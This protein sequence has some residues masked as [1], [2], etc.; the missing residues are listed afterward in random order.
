MMNI[1]KKDYIIGLDIGSSSIKLAEF[2]KKEDGLHLVKVD[3]KELAYIGD[4]ASAEKETLAL[5]KRMLRGSNIKKSKFIV[6]INCPKTAIKN[7]ITPHMPKGELRNAIKLAAKNY[8]PFSI[9]DA[10]LDF[11]ILGEVVEKGVKKYKILVAAS[12][13]K[14][15]SKFLSILDKAGIKPSS[16]MPIPYALRG[17]AEAAYSKDKETRCFLDIG[18]AHT[19]LV[20]FKGKDLVFSRMIPVAGSDLTKEMTDVLVSDKG[21]TE[22]SLD[23]AEKIKREIGIPPEGESKM[24]NDKISTIQILSM[25][26]TPLERLINEID[27][28]FDYYREENEGGRVDSLVLLGGGASLRGIRNFLSEGLGMEVRLGNPLDGLKIKSGAIDE[29]ASSIA[30]KLAVAV[31]AGLSETRGLNLLPPEIR[32]ET[33]QTFKRA[34]VQA[35]VTGI[36]LI[37]A[38]VYIGMRIQLAS[39]QKRIAAG[40]MEILSLQPQIE[41]VETQGLANE[42]LVNEPYWEDVFKELSNIIPDNTYLTEFL[43]KDKTVKIRGV[44]TSSKPEELLS[45]FILGMEKGIFN[46]VRLISTKEIRDKFGN[47]FELDCRVD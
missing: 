37:L 35:I 12:P 26:R 27:R 14:T 16:F 47:E 17:L 34:T 10:L 39:F 42:I 38:L 31:G 13:Q 29:A 19:E 1:L 45:G 15:I 2:L 4:E 43:M 41:Q 40:R 3:V 24:I 28:C 33:K 9:D 20:I 32:E 5:L 36:A 8:F 18:S 22:L 44:V 46:N 21:R 30:H 23:E 25:I 11:E 6:S 7:V